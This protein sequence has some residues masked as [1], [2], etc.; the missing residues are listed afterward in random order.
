MKIHRDNRINFKNLF[1]GWKPLFGLINESFWR[2]I[3]G[4]FFAFVF[5]IIFIAILGSVLGYSQLLGGALAIAP[6]SI[7]TTSM[8]TLMFEF[9]KSSLLKRIGSTPIKASSFLWVAILYYL[10]IIFASIVWCIVFSMLMFGIPHWTS[11]EVVAEGI[12]NVKPALISMNF[13]QTLENVNWIG[14]IWGQLMLTIVGLVFGMMLVAI[15][16]STPA[17]QA[18][19][20][21]VLITSQF[22][23][24]MVLP[25]GTVREIEPLWYL[26][27]ALSPFKAPTNMILE[28]WNGNVSIPPMTEIMPP[29][30]SMFQQA[31]GQMQIKDIN[32]FDHTTQG[33]PFDIYK[34]YWYFNSSGK[35]IL[36]LG[37]AE[38][39]ITLI[40]PF[41]WM[42]I[43]GFVSLKFFKWTSR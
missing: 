25:I 39:I 27:Y 13:R 5:P 2:G 28:S 15:F 38:K 37:K 30:A 6:M 8:P 1:I 7:T 43:F 34:E 41:V 19:G 18:I 16:K 14:F 11:G 23:T 40:L 17:I 26:G 3:F 21:T 31:P 29:A 4:P 36:I 33:N 42:A 22:L 12:Q 9:K 35:N 24:A 32:I 10:M 20:T